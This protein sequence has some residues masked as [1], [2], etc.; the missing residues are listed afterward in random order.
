MNIEQFKNKY[1]QFKDAE[2]IEINCDHPQHSGGSI[3]IGK[4]PAKRNILKNDGK[5]FICRECYMRHNNPMNQVGEKRQT[6]EIIE[7]YC[8][9]SDHSGEPCRSMK[10]SCYY[11]SMQEPFLQLCGSC[12]K[13]F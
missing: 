7:V 2:K 6:D 11:G 4:Q 9:C 13:T 8:P 12:V 5:Q 1:A 3:T 10:K